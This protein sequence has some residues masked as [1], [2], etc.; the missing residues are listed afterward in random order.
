MLFRSIDCR[1][2]PASPVAWE[3]ER[4]VPAVVAPVVVA[5]DTAAGTAWAAV[6]ANGAEAELHLARIARQETSAVPW[7]AVGSRRPLA[8]AIAVQHDTVV[9]VH[10][11]PAQV[12]SVWLAIVAGPSQIPGMRDRLT[13]TG[14][15]VM[16][17]G[18]A[19]DGGRLGAAWVEAAHPGTGPITVVRVGCLARSSP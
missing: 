2:A 19:F 14:V 8:A 6:H 3:P 5:A 11:S 18:A 1:R 13:G 7:I 17:L 12:G 9:L 15:R 10:Q 4:R 16:G